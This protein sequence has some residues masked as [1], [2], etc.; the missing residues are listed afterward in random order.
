MYS[1]RK[2]KLLL[3][4]FFIIYFQYPN[5]I[6][7]LSFYNNKN[8]KIAYFKIQKKNNTDAV[9]LMAPLR[10]N[11]GDQAIALSEMKFLKEI[12]PKIKLVYFNQDFHNYIHNNT[13]IFLLGGGNLGWTYKSEEKKRR[14][15][16][17][18][19]PSN[20]IIIFPQT[21]YFEEG[22]KAQ[23]KKTS[24][25]YSNHSKLIIITREK[26]SYNIANNIFPKNKILLT[27]DIVTYLDDL[28]NLNNK[29]R[30]GAL[31]L[32]RKDR[33]QYLDKNKRKKFIDLIQ[34]AYNKYD[35]SD[36]YF[37]LYINSLEKSK[38]KISNQLKFISEHELVVTD[39]LHGMIFS[40]I[41]ET[42]CIV[43]R[44]YNHKLTSSYEW[45]KHLDYIKMMNTSDVNEF[46]NLI[47]YFK[48]KKTQN[49][50]NKKYFEQYY[51][52]IRETIFNLK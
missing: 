17:K 38:E 7:L 18:S 37:R 10:G 33:E 30:K 5:I 48:N 24:E 40:A 3:I 20:S 49:I 15:I 36:N 11:L 47:Y 12:L 22:R 19:Y 16:I 46:L 39:R 26:I 4:T 27:P 43:I 28:I 8:A 42:S 21:I 29:E 51:N 50:Y 44:N 9:L 41:T 14:E 32:L 31:F 1:K 13:I 23:E 2:K 34:K 45:F 6:Y 35:I 52:L 25:I